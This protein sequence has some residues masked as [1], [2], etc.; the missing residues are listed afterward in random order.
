MSAEKNDALVCDVCPRRCRLSPGGLGACRA[1]RNVG[2]AVVAES[3]G[4][5][6][7]L[8][9]D[10]VEKKPLARFMPGT[11]VVSVGSYGCNLRCP[12]CQN[13]EIAQAGEKDVRT[14]EVMP[15]ELV[16][17]TL[18][19]RRRDGRVSGIAYT[20]NEPLVTW[21]Y[22][23]DCARL[24]REAGL[25]N[26]LVSNGCVEPAVIDE[27]EGLLDAA[28]IDLKGFSD[29]FYEA[30]GGAPG[31]LAYVR[32][33]IE[34][35]AADPCCHLEVTTLVVPGMNDGEEEIDELAGWLASLD[36]G[37]GRETIAHHVTRFF[38]RWRLTDRP[39]TPVEVVRGLDEV[40]RRHL[41]HVYVGN[42]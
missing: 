20:Y 10:P 30:C 22:V 42:C 25:V 34:R 31:S 6:T 1:R 21:E 8:A 15:D 41:D 12:F 24:A 33:T 29:A 4:R 35:L 11:Y 19:A 7:S 40:S 17:M 32:G 9:L 26:V 14:R 5:L 37:R 36:G 16:A 3:Y 18:E 38:P 28:N 27:L 23:R 13:W 39:P 2:G